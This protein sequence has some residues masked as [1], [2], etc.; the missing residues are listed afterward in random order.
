MKIKN[1]LIR[2][3]EVLVAV[4]LLAAIDYIT[5]PQIG[6][7]NE[8]LAG[9]FILAAAAALFWGRGYGYAALVFAVCLYAIP[10]RLLV[11]LYYANAQPAPL[12]DMFKGNIAGFVITIPGIY[13]AGSILEMFRRWKKRALE[14]LKELTKQNH[15]LSR[16]KWAYNKVLHELEAR[17]SRQRESITYLFDQMQKLNSLNF[18]KAMTLITETIRYF[19]SASLIKVWK[20]NPSANNFELYINRDINNHEAEK[21]H[22]LPLDGTI[23]GWVLRNKRVFTI[24]MILQYDNLYKMESGRNI[25]TIPL[26]L[27]DNVWGVVNIQKMPFEKYN[28]YTERILQLIVELV[29]PPLERALSFE[30]IVTEADYSPV[31]NL[32]LFSRF[33]N[34]LSAEIEKRKEMQQAHLSL[35]ILEII[36]YDRIE[37]EFDK[38]AAFLLKQVAG[39]LIRIGQQDIHVFH[40]KENNQL[41]I[42]FPL[43]DSD[44]IS[45]FGLDA[46]EAINSKEWMINEHPTDI[47]AVIAYSTFSEEF[48]TAE[49]MITHAESLLQMQKM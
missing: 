31:T 40:Y 19:T 27:H 14:K 24:R 18:N 13:V 17:V 9:A 25:L 26:V 20:F 36:N 47:E 6:F 12:L 37:A 35:V 5:S 45:M 7:T 15:I 46:L 8:G 28:L 1:Q 34:Y 43:M 38:K 2:T 48:D 4:A 32:P 3:F 29:S 49:K 10:Y 41:A 39:E 23:E 11:P 42:V 44:G 16:E 21:E 33:Y 30:A 22:E